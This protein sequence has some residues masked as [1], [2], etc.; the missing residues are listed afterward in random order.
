[1]AQNKKTARRSPRELK[2]NVPA[3]DRALHILMPYIF[4][5]IAIYFIFCFIFEEKMGFF[6]KAGDLLLGLFSIGGYAFPLLLILH[7]WFY[8][9]DL[10]AG[11]HVYKFWFSFGDMTLLGVLCGAFTKSCA[12]WNPADNFKGGLHMTTGGLVGGTFY[13]ALDFCVGM[14]TPVLAVLGIIIFTTFLFYLI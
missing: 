11:S 7:A 10:S 12:T 8:K 9:R 14:F 4:W 6:G 13:M 3:E 1:M 5:L 2:K